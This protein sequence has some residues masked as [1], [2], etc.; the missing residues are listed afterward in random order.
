MQISMAS[1]NF[2]RARPKYLSFDAKTVPYYEGGTGAVQECKIVKQK[3]KTRKTGN[4]FL[5]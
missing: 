5:M 4:Y 1:H 3:L 2:L